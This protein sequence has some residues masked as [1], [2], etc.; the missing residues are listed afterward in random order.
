MQALQHIIR[1]DVK[2]ARP[3]VTKQ[4]VPEPSSLRV[5]QASPTKQRYMAVAKM[6]A[7][8]GLRC[9]ICHRPEGSCVHTRLTRPAPVCEKVDTPTVS[10]RCQPHHMGTAKDDLLSSPLA[11]TCMRCHKSRALVLLGHSVLR[12]GALGDRVLALLSDRQ[13][14]NAG[15]LRA[16]PRLFG[17]LLGPT[18]Q[19]KGVRLSW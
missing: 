15:W 10:C 14:R 19:V 11:N 16:S 2:E 4:K 12:S 3:T 8:S 5:P 18:G 6:L 17:S 13:V 7:K 1:L 9:L